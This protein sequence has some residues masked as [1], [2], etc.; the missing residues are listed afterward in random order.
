LSTNVSLVNVSHAFGPQTLFTSVNAVLAGGD[1]I[2]L[3]GVNGSGKSTLMRIIAGQLEPESG[4]V[5]AEKNTR[6]AY[7]PQSGA[8]LSGKSLY[9]EA[10]TAYAR[11]ERMASEMRELEKEMRA[12]GGGADW[13]LG[14][15]TRLQEALESSDYY[16]RRYTIE[17]VLAG[18]GFSDEDRSRPACAF[19]SGWQ[20]RIALARVLLE[21]ADVLL[22]DEPTNYLDLEARNW[23][24]G[25]L[26]T[27]RGA[28]LLVS[29][30]RYFLDMTVSK[31]MEIY[32]RR[33][34]I[35][36]G[37]FTAYEKKREAE[38]REVV[39]RLDRQ[40]EERARIEA[41]VRRFRYNASKARLV[42]S[43]IRQLQKME[44]IEIPPGIRRMHFRFPDPPHCGRAALQVEGLAKSYGD[45][46][47]LS[48]VS[49]DLM[50][51]ERLVVVG[52]NGAGKSTLMRILAR[53]TRADSGTVRYGKDVAAG[54]FSPEYEVPPEDEKTVFQVVEEEAPSELYPR[55]KDLL[56]A[57]LFRGD[58]VYKSVKV[59]SGGERSRLSLVELLLRRVNLL[60]L[61]EPTNHLDMVS[62]DILLDALKRYT[63]TVV[64]VSHDR[65]FIEELAT[66]VLE[67]DGGRSHLYV[68]GYEYYLWKKEN[69]GQRNGGE[70]GGAASG[71]IEN[72]PGSK[73][74]REQRKE[75][76]AG[77]RRLERREEE[78]LTA[79]E[80]LEA[81]NK[82][83]DEEMARSYRDGDRMKRLKAERESNA[84]R[85]A[86][87]V[88]QWERVGQRLQA[89]RNEL[90]EP[91][92]T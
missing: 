72:D 87:L 8:P 29:H 89:L 83:L 40:Q 82:A 76:L 79:M 7:L 39:R 52:P 37:N 47:A 15:Y 85:Q 64:F 63:G 1:H 43:R 66:K 9:E 2:A 6:I 71:R 51:G 75:V 38:L 32:M 20:M 92:S 58:D 61:D 69:G 45:K 25:F 33:V 35:Y 4:R 27:Y 10:E 84:A 60:L 74:W 41:F 67:L 5:V 19:S 70:P 11:F 55:L 44:R 12:P 23:L 90:G 57:F 21:D 50:R 65:L 22:L 78:M 14:R 62:K 34:K 77:V 53:R 16:E 49:F 88:H 17:K 46:T 31:V 28:V 18:L 56:G 13:V 30:D 42:R 59:L 54:Y 80:Q 81:G 26:A 48:G 73:A 86:E 68:G 36:P 3:T 24:E 91:W